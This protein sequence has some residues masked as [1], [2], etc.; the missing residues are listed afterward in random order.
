VT[1]AAIAPRA[2][3]AE[4]LRVL[5]PTD[6]FLPRV[7]GVSTSIATF[8]RELAAIGVDAHVVCPRYRDEAAVPGVTRIEGWTVPLDPEDRFV[9]PG[10]FVAATAP[11]DFDLVHVQTPFAAHRAGVRLARA[12]GVPLVETWHTDFE[13]YF[14]HYLPLVPAPLA[15]AVGRSIARRVGRSVDRLVVPSSAVDRAL[16]ASGVTTPR[17]ILPT[18]LT[19][20]DLGVGDGGRFR[21]AHGIAPDRPVAVHVGRMAREKNVGFLLEVADRVRGEIPDLLLVLAGEGP[22]RPELERQVARLGLGPNV[23]FLGYLDRRI[24]LA[25]CYRAGDCFLFS[26]TTETQ[27]LVLLEAMSL[28]VPVVALAAGGTVDLLAARR[29]ALV[30]EADR[31]VFAAAVVRLLRDR[32]LAARLSREAREEAGRWS[33]GAFARRLASLYGELIEAAPARR[34]AAVTPAV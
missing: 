4:R 19:A 23:L 17:V 32:D 6:V 26:S 3:A 21:A 13:H 10:S 8:R 11:L 20:E 30:P 7:N 27:G 14:E 18:G 1:V 31:E 15:R 24:G 28:G 16:A 34:H 2:A 25:D 22:A 29:G 5:Y 9:R 12:R 33:A